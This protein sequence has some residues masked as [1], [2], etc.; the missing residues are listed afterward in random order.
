MP[1]RCAASWRTTRA[2]PLA[3]TP[4]ITTYRRYRP[5]GYQGIWTSTIPA[6]IKAAWNGLSPWRLAWL[7][8]RAGKRHR[9]TGRLV[10][11]WT[12]TRPDRTG[13]RA[14][15]IQEACRRRLFQNH[16]S[17]GSGRIARPWIPETPDRRHYHLRRRPYQLIGAPHINHESLRDKGFTKTKIDEIED[18]LHDAFDIKFAFNKWT[19]GAEFLIQTSDSG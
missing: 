13:F 17:G 15:Q 3:R 10:S 8:Q 4:V 14:R 16:Q 19:L 11:L 1:K 18:R 6:R 12:A 9:P 5:A 2:P 7:S